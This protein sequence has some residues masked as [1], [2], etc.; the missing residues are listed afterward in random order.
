MQYKK[1]IDNSSKEL[2]LFFNGWAMTPESVDHIASKE[3]RDIVVVWDYRNDDIDWSI[4]DNYE[5]L[6]IVAWSMGV[7]QV[8][9]IINKD[10]PKID[11]LKTLTAIAGTTKP[12]S[13]EYGIPNA[14]FK[15][16]LDN[17]NE[18]NRL[19]FNR[20]MCGARRFERLFEALS[21]RETSEIKDEL[22]RVYQIEANTPF[23][24]DNNIWTKVIIAN[25][26][27]II[28]YQNQLRH[29][30]AFNLDNMIVMDA[31]HYTFSDIKV[32]EDIIC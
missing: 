1:I 12:M 25:K 20:R 16:T 2:I 30:Q 9:R 18:E 32:W 6:H 11:I 3:N 7:W 27:R 24:A 15:A 4:L 26:D 5:A 23:V 19:K 10:F 21:K 28:P 22:Q 8:N 31:E 17:L 29:W 13:D 14:V